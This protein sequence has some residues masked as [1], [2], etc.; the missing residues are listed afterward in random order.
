MRLV[1]LTHK[2]RNRLLP[3][4]FFTYSILSIKESNIINAALYKMIT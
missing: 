4:S 1:F 2:K 3:N